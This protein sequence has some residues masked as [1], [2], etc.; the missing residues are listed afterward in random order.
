[1]LLAYASLPLSIAFLGVTAGSYVVTTNEAFFLSVA[2]TIGAVWSIILLYIGLQTVHNYTAKETIK[3]ILLTFLL[4]FVV[5]VVIMIVTIMWDQVWTFLS[6]LGEE[7]T[8]NV[9]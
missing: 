6:T 1:M 9:L 3:A 7:L 2:L 5:V 8:Q 4:I